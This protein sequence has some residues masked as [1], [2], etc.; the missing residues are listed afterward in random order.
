[1]PI[2]VHVCLFLHV[3]IVRP[4]VYLTI[5]LSKIVPA[6][7]FL[8]FHTFIA[9]YGG[10]SSLGSKSYSLTILYQ[11]NESPILSAVAMFSDA[12]DHETAFDEQTC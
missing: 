7:L 3:R 4:S 12:Y 6:E 9:R 8:K 10:S 5:R 1:M 11:V 2:Q